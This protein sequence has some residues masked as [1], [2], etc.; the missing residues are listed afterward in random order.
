MVTVVAVVVQSKNPWG[1]SEGLREPEDPHRRSDVLRDAHYPKEFVGIEAMRFLC[2]IA[3]IILHYQHFFV[4][5]LWPSDANP[6]RE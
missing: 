1:R 3:I 4:T 5:G 2:A 6:S